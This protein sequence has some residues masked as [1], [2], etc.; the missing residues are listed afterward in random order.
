MPKEGTPDEITG[1]ASGTYLL[2]KETGEVQL[3]AG[4]RLLPVQA[5][6]PAE[7]AAGNA[8]NW[9]AENPIGAPGT[10]VTVR[11]KYRDGQMLYE[12]TATPLDGVLKDVYEDRSREAA[13]ILQMLD[14]DAFPVGEEIDLVLR[15]G[16]P[17]VNLEGVAT[18]LPWTGSASMSEASYR[19]LSSSQIGWRGFPR[20][21]AA[22]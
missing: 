9:P 12:V 17:V 14:I 10:T 3:I 20:P 4:T 15:R 2:N 5:P 6:S 21:T 11:T 16:T 18:K 7:G 1:S 19:A 8:K 22:N 13:F